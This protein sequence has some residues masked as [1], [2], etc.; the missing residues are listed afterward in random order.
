RVS[1]S[2]HRRRQGDLIGAA[3]AARTGIGFLDGLSDTAVDGGVARSRLALELVTSLLDRGETAVAFDVA[4]P[5]L[6][7]PL[8]AAA[9]APVSWLRLAVATR[10][11]LAAGA[12]YAATHLLRDAVHDTDRHSMRALSARLRSELAHVEER[13]GR[14]AD[15]L[16]TLR[17][18]RADERAHARL[19]GRAYA[20]LTG[21]F[22]VGERPN[23]DF[24]EI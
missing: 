19:R 10:V 5:I 8:R 11:H 20:V 13:M 16:E 24:T 2:A 22:G 7:R 4:G 9:I 3:D 15:A 21:E 6:A 17:G 12:G 14:P 1:M 23:L 18:A